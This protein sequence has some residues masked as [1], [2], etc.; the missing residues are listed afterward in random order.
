MRMKIAHL[1]SAHPRDDARIFRKMCRSLSG[2]GHD[3][4]LVVAD[5]KGDDLN[6]PIK[7]LDAG[8]SSGRLGRMLTAPRR[9]QA[10]ALGTGADLYHLHDPELLPVGLALK[11]AGKRV[12][13]DAHED[14]PAAIMAKPYLPG[15]TR[16]AVAALTGAYLAHAGKRLDGVV[17]ATPHIRRRFAARGVR[18]EVVANYPLTGAGLSVARPRA[19]AVCYVGGLARARGLR[20]MLAA[21]DQADGETRLVLAGDLPEWARGIPGWARTDAVGYLSAPDVCDLLSISVAGLVTLHPTPAYRVALPVKMFE[22]M[23]A[24]LPVIASDF[25]LWR[26]IIEGAECGLWWT[27]STPR[28]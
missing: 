22:Y 8:R 26:E 21:I 11:R 20:E 2:A 28:P 25:P 13:F 14:Y 3:V 1:T 24:G 27:P 9:V 5:G 12:I 16:P 23:A 15:F 4:T 18:C 17:A 19:N 6:G 7:V 10:R